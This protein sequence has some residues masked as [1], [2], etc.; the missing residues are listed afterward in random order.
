M[1]YYVSGKLAYLDPSIAVIDAGGVGYK[2]IITQHT[3]DAMPPHLSVSE[4][5]TVK[6]FS[7]MSVREDAVELYG[8]ISED[9]LSAFKS[10]ITVSGVGPKAAV[11]ILSLLTP[12]KLAL[13]ICTED[14]KAISAANGI[15][16]KTA[17]RIILELKDKMKNHSLPSDIENDSSPIVFSDTPSTKLSDA[18]DALA[19]LGYSRSEAISALKS[20]DTTNLELDEIIK[21]ALKKLMR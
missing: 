12:A 19:V 3:H 21:Q 6:L 7:Y 20:I 10:L 13:A 17:A 15:G 1:F 8:F 11:S 18:Q 5:P 16:P 14:K 2:F 9:E 4:P